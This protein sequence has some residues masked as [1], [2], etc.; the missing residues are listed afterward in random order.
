MALLLGH[1]AEHRSIQ[2]ARSAVEA[3]IQVASVERPQ[4]MIQEVVPVEAEL[5]LLRLLELEVLEES[6]I[7]VE[8]RRS[9]DRRQH[10]R[11]V[12]P[13]CGRDAETARV[14]VLVRPRGSQSDC[15]SGPGSAGYRVCPA[16]TR[17]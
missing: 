5:Q 17:C 7:G 8:E 9:V 12:L 14:D 16:A 3:E 6:Q 11:A 2:L 4:R 1:R 15:R 13:D 10:G